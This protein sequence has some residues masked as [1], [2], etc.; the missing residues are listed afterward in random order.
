MIPHGQ[1]GLF[2]AF[3]GLDGAGTTTQVNLLSK[4]LASRGVEVMATSQP[5]SAFIGQLI[6][7]ILK[8]RWKA[9]EQT[10][11]LLFSADRSHHLE[12][13]VIPALAQGRVVVTD[14]YYFSTIAYGSHKL[15]P[16][17][18]IALQKN[19]ISPDLTFLIEVPLKECLRRLDRDRLIREIYE[20]KETLRRVAEGY[21]WVKERFPGEIVTIDG[22]RSPRL[23]GQEVLN[24][25]TKHPKITQ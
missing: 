1:P 4:R 5:S 23:I 2:I 8:G 18:L 17:W 25:V 21:R 22:T 20:K 10:I 3:E 14:R 16:E 11:Q 6:R 7:Q 9:S 19:F 15:D 13:T 12:E 24:E